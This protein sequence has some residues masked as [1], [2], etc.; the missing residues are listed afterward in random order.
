MTALGPI[1]ELLDNAFGKRAETREL[2]FLPGALSVI[3]TPPSPTGRALGLI[4]MAFF[5]LAVLWSIL[6]R[7][8]VLATAPGSLTPAG[9]VKTVQPLDSGIVRNIRVQNGDHVKAGQVLVELDPTEATADTDRLDR[10]LTQARLDDARLSALKG[11]IESG[12]EPVLAAPSG[13]SAAVVEEAAAAMRAQSAQQAAKVADLS[14]QISQKTAEMAEVDAQVAKIEATL[15]ALAKKEEIQRQLYEEGFGTMGRLLDAQI[16]LTEAKHELLVQGAKGDQAKAARAALEKARDEA[17]SQYASDVLSDMRKAARDENELSQELIK[18]KNKIREAILRSPISGV[19]EQLNVHTLGGVVTPAQ[20]LLIVVPDEQQ[21][22]IEA[23]LANRDVGFVHAGQPVK[24][25]VET[26]NFTRYGFID[27]KVVEVS[28]DVAAVDPTALRDPEAA[29]ARALPE[30]P[31]YTARI[32]ISRTFMSVDGRTE[33]LR[34][35]MA[36]TTEIKTGERSIIS[37]LFSPL[38][39]RT[40]ESLHER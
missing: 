36:V 4:I 15:P 31:T 20:H 16:P 17:R 19:V 38:A 10:D 27:G 22:M 21:F 28:R 18:A 40:Q 14:Q 2:A 25:K 9:D 5:T 30:S 32:S 11:S 12:R 33:S 8:D 29:K 35:G 24:V 23:Q 3:E 39:R 7:V 37:Y 13:L 6:G 26:F 1:G 34:P